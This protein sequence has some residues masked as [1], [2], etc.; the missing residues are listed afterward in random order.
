MNPRSEPLLWVQL[1]S[2]G[3]VPLELLLLLLLLGGS[4]P[5]PLPLLERLL[6]WTLGA[7]AP[8]V[9]LWR[10]PADLRSLLLIK[11]ALP[12]P[13]ALQCTLAARQIQPLPRLV[14]AA[15]VLAL[16]P[17]LGWLDAHAALASHFSPL[18][19]GPRLTALLL[20]AGLLALMVWQWQQL[21]QASWLLLRGTAD[22]AAVTP[23]TPEQV[24]ASRSNPGLALLL[25]PALELEAAA[26]QTAAASPQAA[27]AATAGPVVHQAPGVDSL[28]ESDDGAPAIGQAQP[29]LPDAD[30][31][32]T[33][34]TEAVAS[35]PARS[36]VTASSLLTAQLETKPIELVSA[37]AEPSE[38]QPGEHDDQ[39]SSAEAVA[40]EPEQSAE[41]AESTELDQQIRGEDLT[42][43]C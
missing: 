42:S 7:L 25:L 9:L 30:V 29:G 16:F 23:L 24:A 40:V 6:T 39:V 27:N 17:L 22:L 21:V 4:D 34:A 35:E 14:F 3:A 31:S 5:G 10:R 18:A 36:D 43:G 41:Q 11:S 15:G 38:A 26:T 12:Q 13:S 19:D 1:I 20:G 33:A 28:G 37:E 32:G 8:A 2:I